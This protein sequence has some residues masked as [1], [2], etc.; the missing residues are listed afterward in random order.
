MLGQRHEQGGGGR[1]IANM[2]ARHQWRV[3]FWPDRTVTTQRPGWMSTRR[4][5]GALAGPG[6]SPWRLGAVGTARQPALRR[7]CLPAVVGRGV[8][9]GARKA[10]WLNWDGAESAA[11]VEQR[12]SMF[13][14]MSSDV[15]ISS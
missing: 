14:G 10:K 15:S 7:S 3:A 12:S 13:S 6:P 4:H 11:M 8:R 2:P 5:V 9:S 1:R